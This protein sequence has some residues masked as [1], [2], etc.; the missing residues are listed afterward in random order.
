MPD[1]M[2]IDAER[3]RILLA[4]QPTSGK[5]YSLLALADY[6]S[7]HNPKAKVF[8][9]DADRGVG[10]VHKADFSHV[11]FAQQ[12]LGR[13]WED[14]VKFIADVGAVQTRND[15]VLID[16]LG[17]FWDMAQNLEVS[18]VHG[19][20]TGQA[21]LEACK[22][23]VEASKL[24]A[25]GTL[26][27]P[28]WSIIKRFHNEEFIDEITL[29]WDAN[30]VATT[31]LNKLDTDRDDAL[32]VEVFAKYGF[33]PEGEKHNVHRFDTVMLIEAESDRHYLS[34]A[35]DRGRTLMH[36]VQFGESLWETYADELKKAGYSFCGW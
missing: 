16:M 23:M 25:P 9:L 34:T 17:R 8:L 20:S 26:A 32:L 28:D 24:N 21:M 18:A 14:V 27:Q 12:H 33:R 10:R 4:G 31:S 22:K 19:V 7:I 2:E 30:V 36:H 15:W 1:R 3:E 6:V 5:T 29:S 13:R 11:K 35:K